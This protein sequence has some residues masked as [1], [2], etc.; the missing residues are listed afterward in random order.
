MAVL[1]SF[2]RACDIAMNVELGLPKLV[3]D[4][5]PLASY[6]EAL[7]LLRSGQGLKVQVTPNTK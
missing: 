2:D 1:H 3:T 5:F 6:V 7:Q 4:T